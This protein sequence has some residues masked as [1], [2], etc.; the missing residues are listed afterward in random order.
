MSRLPA[1]KAM[2]PDC[3]RIL[4]A[5]LAALLLVACSGSSFA[6]Y[7]PQ[8]FEDVIIEVETRPARVEEG[9][10]EFLVIATRQP[11]RPAHNLLIHISIDDTG[12]WQQAIQDGHMGVY[13]RALAVTDPVN[14]V[15][16]VRI[17]YDDRERTLHFPLAQTTL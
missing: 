9:M 4:A 13:R 7:P 6:P 2:A 11:R 15:L 16:N 8:V 14:N 17:R 3:S 5:L 10:I 1:M 12:V